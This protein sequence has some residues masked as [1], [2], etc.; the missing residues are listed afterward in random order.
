MAIQTDIGW[1]TGG[2]SSKQNGGTFIEGALVGGTIGAING[3]L[4]IISPIKIPFGE[5][6]FG[7][8]I[9]PQFAVD[10]D[11]LGIG[12][13]ANVGYDLGKGFTAGVNFGGTLYASSAGTGTSGFEGRIGYGVGYKGEHFQLGIGSNYFFS[14]ETSQ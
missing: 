11:G 2:I 10:T 4:S 1:I 12:V 14:G 9:A 7:L 5:S 8:S 3:A 13:N 6:G